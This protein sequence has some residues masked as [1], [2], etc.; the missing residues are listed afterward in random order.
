MNPHDD[1]ASALFVA[2]IFV[3]LGYAAACSVKPFTTCKKCTGSG[4]RRTR[5][6][7][8]WRACRPC[9]GSGLRLRIG[10]RIYNL[11]AHLYREGSR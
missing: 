7:H 11:L 10:R 9:K 4:R 5:I 8:R 6:A 3:T 1:A 2:T